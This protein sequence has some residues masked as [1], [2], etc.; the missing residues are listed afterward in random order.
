MSTISDA[1][2][3]GPGLAGRAQR[4]LHEL[5]CKRIDLGLGP[6]DPSG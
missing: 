1:P 6:N 4:L 2:A 3:G 5:G